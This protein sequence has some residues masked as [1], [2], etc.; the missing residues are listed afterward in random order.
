MKW[1]YILLAIP[2]A[3]LIGSYRSEPPT[4]TGS[5]W[6]RDSV[7]AW[8]DDTNDSYMPIGDVR[9]TATVVVTDSA[10]VFREDAGDSAAAHAGDS[11]TTMRGFINDTAQVVRGEIADTA[12]IYIE[13]SL[14]NYALISA[15]EDSTDAAREDGGD[16]ASVYA[17]AVRGDLADTFNVAR[18]I[19]ATWTWDGGNVLASDGQKFI[20]TDDAEDDSGSIYISNDSLIITATG[21]PIAIGEEGLTTCDS[22]EIDDLIRIGD[23]TDTVEIVPTHIAV[24]TVT[25]T[26]LDGEPDTTETALTTYVANHGSSYTVVSWCWSTD[27]NSSVSAGNGSQIY[28]YGGFTHAE[29]D[30]IIIDSLVACWR[31]QYDSVYIDSVYLTPGYQAREGALDNSTVLWG[32]GTDLELGS[33][34]YFTHSHTG[35]NATV[36][37]DWRCLLLANV[38]T[39]DDAGNGYIYNMIVYG[40]YQ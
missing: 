18:E 16:S 39:T 24:D 31:T 14:N 27:Y 22:L 30:S 12:A 38:E 5:G 23:G 37:R 29:E 36:S 10:G 11:A 3:L 1:Y 15:L 17:A 35:V 6:S 28:L 8:W 21:I 26:Y 2:L 40:H 34:G 13:D 32:D 7:N 20:T 4:T 33:N 9:D 19:T 25:A